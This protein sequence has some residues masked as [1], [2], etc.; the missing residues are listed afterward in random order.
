MAKGGRLHKKNLGVV[1]MK[2]ATQVFALLLAAAAPVF[3]SPSLRAQEPQEV[4]PAPRFEIKRFE[5]TGNTLLPAGDVER[6]VAPFTGSG[7]DFSDIQRALEAL[8]QAYR[9]RGFGV[10]QVLLPEQDITRG[11]VQFRVVQPRVGRVAIEGNTHF[12]SDNVRRSLPSIREGEVPNSA[13]IARNLQLAA[14]HPVKQTNVLLRSGQT[15]ETVD[16]NVKVTDDR[17]WRR[18]VTLDNTGTSDTGY[19][20]LGLGFQHTNLFDRDHSLTMQYVTSPTYLSKVSIFGAGY[21]IPYYN[22]NSSLDL[23]AGY[24]DVNS[25][26]VQGLFNVAGSGFIGAARWNTVLPKWGDIE[27]KISLGMDYR[28]FENE[29][30]FQNVNLTPDITVHPISLTYSGLR[31]MTAA[32]FSYYVGLSHN[33]PGGNDG[34]EEDWR[35]GISARQA[36]TDDYKIL[37]F[38]FNYAR[39]FR[40]EWQMRLGFNAQYTADALVSG[41]QFG[42]GGPDSVRGYP[43]RE[44]SN[45]YGYSAQAE[46]YTPDF[47][48]KVSLSDSYK[49]RALAFYDWGTTKR[50]KDAGP[51][52][53]IASFGLGLRL[54]YGKM[55]NFRLDLAQILQETP[56]RD[57]DSQRVSGALAIVF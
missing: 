3:Y 45:D 39:Q 20:R 41:E 14:E 51:E 1:V 12:S 44:V 42:I 29:V 6:L 30:L 10:V 16:V 25:G 36:V 5:V 11:V 23:I 55:V 50:N 48:R 57:N 7:K 22:L 31:R 2:R 40:N 34:K 46:I 54:S 33:I 15:E 38:G 47:S 19:Y 37:R 24:S 53:S 9:E 32:D 27:H 49:L 52:D 56:S 8:E 43:L 18:F 26:V 28:A 4:I 21:R 17:P 13:E 35:N